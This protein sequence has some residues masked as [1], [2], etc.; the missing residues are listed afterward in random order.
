MSLTIT[1]SMQE[2]CENQPTSKQTAFFHIVE[3]SLQINEPVTASS[4]VD[5][6]D[7]VH[8]YFGR[9]PFCRLHLHGSEP[10]LIVRGHSSYEYFWSW[11]QLGRLLQRCEQLNNPY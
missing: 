3:T 10:R 11:E 1:K 8:V 9:T 2:F 5:E 4:I 6:M 7:I